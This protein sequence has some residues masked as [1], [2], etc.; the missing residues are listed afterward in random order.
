MM[1]NDFDWFEAILIVV[2]IIGA[3]LCIFY[4]G[5]VIYLAIT[6]QLPAGKSDDPQIYY[7]NGQMYIM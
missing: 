6:G 7:I 1:D 2:G 3:L 5:A 4:I